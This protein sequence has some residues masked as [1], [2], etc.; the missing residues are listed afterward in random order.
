MFKSKDPT[1]P[2][3]SALTLP[4]LSARLAAGLPV[5]VREEASG[6]ARV[7]YRHA[8]D[9]T[10]VSADMKA[11]EGGGHRGEVGA[12]NRPDPTPEASTWGPALSTISLECS[13]L[14]LGHTAPGDVVPA[15]FNHSWNARQQMV[16]STHT[17]APREPDSIC[18]FTPAPRGGLDSFRFIYR[19]HWRSRDRGL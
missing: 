17:G 9:Y 19:A 7:T 15:V 18:V 16:L 11:C 8:T 1:A 13:G 10:T 14:T 4:T 2:D 3:C 6:F 12:Q 5:W